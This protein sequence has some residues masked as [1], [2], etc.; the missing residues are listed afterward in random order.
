M[1]ADWLHEKIISL[2]FL[3]AL[4]VKRVV[5]FPRIKEVVLNGRRGQ[6]NVKVYDRLVL[7][8]SSGHRFW[9]V[10]SK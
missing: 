9:W 4:E 7:F 2:H 6:P 3:V 10:E 8:P 5:S 1:K